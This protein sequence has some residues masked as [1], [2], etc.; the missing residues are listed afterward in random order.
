MSRSSK[1]ALSVW[2]VGKLLLVILLIKWSF[3]DARFWDAQK[4]WDVA[5]HEWDEA[6]NRHDNSAMQIALDKQKA[7]VAEQKELLK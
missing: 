6:F 7:I 4:R 5:N 1:I 2:A 3:H